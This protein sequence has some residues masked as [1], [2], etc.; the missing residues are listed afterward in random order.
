MP[1]LCDGWTP[2][3]DDKEFAADLCMNEPSFGDMV[4]CDHD[5]CTIK[6]F[7]FECTLPT[8]RKIVFP[9]LPQTFQIEWKKKVEPIFITASLSCMLFYLYF[10]MRLYYPKKIVHT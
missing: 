4:M 3:D 6:W 1:I 8:E 10:S 2:R 5:K 7:H 9:L